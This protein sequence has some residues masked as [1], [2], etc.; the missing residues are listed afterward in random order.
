MTALASWQLLLLLFITTFGEPLAKVAP[1]ANPGPTG[2]AV[3]IPGT[4]QCLGK[5]PAVRRREI[6]GCRA[7]SP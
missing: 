6:W 7:A 4:H 1:L 3:R 2:P 5:G